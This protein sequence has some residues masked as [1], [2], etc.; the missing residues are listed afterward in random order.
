MYSKPEPKSAEFIQPVVLVGGRSVRFGRDKLREPWN[1]SEGGSWLVDQPRLVLRAVAGRRVWAVGDCDPAVAARFDC[2]VPDSY[3]GAGPLGAILTS[4]RAANSAVIVLAGDLPRIERSVVLALIEAAA[5]RPDAEAVVART[6]H[7]EPCI[8][9]YRPA[10][11]K[12]L[13]ARMEHGSLDL[14]GAM[15]ELD[16]VPVPISSDAAININRETD[17]DRRT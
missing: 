4:L 1:G 10:S 16:V 9:L 2:V 6:D 15:G 14:Q 5:R 17:L 13:A 8:G 12:V 3:P 7:W 11:K